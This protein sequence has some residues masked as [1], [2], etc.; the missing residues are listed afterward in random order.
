[1]RYYYNHGQ[2]AQ[3]HILFIFQYME[4]QL[5]HEWHF[6]RFI[7]INHLNSPQKLLWH[8]VLVGKMLLG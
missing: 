4:A 8:V 7:T 5:F 2:D 1:M 6:T 3:F